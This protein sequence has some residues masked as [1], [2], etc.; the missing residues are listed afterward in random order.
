MPNYFRR[1]DLGSC[2]RCNARSSALSCALYGLTLNVLACGVPAPGSAPVISPASAAGHRSDSA[3]GSDPAATPQLVP[4]TIVSPTHA[5]DVGEM[6]GDGQTFLRRGEPSTAARIFDAIVVHEPLGPFTER[7][8]FQGALAHEQTGNFDA[9]IARFEELARRLPDAS[10]SAEAL[11]RS[12]RLRMH[13]EQWAPAGEAGR[14]FLERYPAAPVA[15]KLV[16][17]AARALGLL[18]G[19][20]VEEAEYFIAKAMEI[21]DQLELDR[22]GS[23]PR[24]L[25]QVYFAQ[26]EARRQRAEA[27]KLSNDASQFAARL[28]RRCELILAAQSAYSDSMRA[29][30]AHWS[31]MAGYRVGELYQRLHDE[32][33]AIPTPRAATERE[34]QLFEG[35]MRLRYSVLLSKASSMMDHTLAMAQRTGEQSAWVQRTEQSRRRLQQAMAAEQ[36]AIDRLPFTRADLQQALDDIEARAA[37]TP[38]AAASPSSRSK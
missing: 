31:T 19:E 36:A 5:A 20:R 21:V 1:R 28:E 3:P 24:D 2:E 12:M 9:A 32:L 30:D 27:V 34:R 18:A 35:A 33:V 22:A 25:A 13:V 6:F 26:G 14:V 8:L 16:A 11:V 10:R 38:P 17:L 4:T 7:A 15:Q 29:Y 37:R 23:I